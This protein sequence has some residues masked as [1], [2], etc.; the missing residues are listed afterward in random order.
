MTCQLFRVFHFSKLTSFASKQGCA[1][2]LHP[3]ACYNFPPEQLTDYSLYNKL[4]YIYDA[5]FWFAELTI[6][7]GGN[8]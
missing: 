7:V 5:N 1:N 6:Q 4:L 8:D 3:L 2:L